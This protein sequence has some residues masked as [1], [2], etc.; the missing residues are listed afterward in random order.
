MSFEKSEREKNLAELLKK[1]DGLEKNVSDIKKKFDEFN[2]EKFNKVI[3]YLL[4]DYEQKLRKEEKADKI[5]KG[6]LKG[7]FQTCAICGKFKFIEELT[8]G[9]AICE[10]CLEKYINKGV[11]IKEA[12]N[13]EKHK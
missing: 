6:F 13:K 5:I 8:K 10:R 3:T 2:I 9:H 11:S 7:R 12:T 1:I 4:Y